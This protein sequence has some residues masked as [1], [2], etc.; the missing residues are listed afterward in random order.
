M[1]YYLWKTTMQPS[2][3]QQEIVD[4]TTGY[5]CVLSPAGSGKTKCI[6]E[7]I[8]QLIENG[9]ESKKILLI[10]FTKKATLEMEERLYNLIGK[11]DVVIGTMHS[12]F[13][14][15]LLYELKKL[16]PKK[17]KYHEILM[18]YKQKKILIEVKEEV[19]FNE[20]IETLL[21]QISQYKNKMINN[22]IIESIEK[23]YEKHKIT[24]DK[25]GNTI[26]LFDFDDMLLKTYELFRDNEYIRNFWGAKWDYIKIDEYQDTNWIQNEIIKYLN[27]SNLM[28][29]GDISQSLYI[30]RGARPEYTQQF[31]E[32][33]P[34]GI[35]HTLNITYRCK[36]EII[37]AANLLINPICGQT[38]KSFHKDKGHVEYLG[39]YTLRSEAK[40]VTEKIKLEIDI[41]SQ[42]EIKILYR[43]NAQSLELEFA[44]NESNIEYYVNNGVSFLDRAICKDLTSY[45][46]VIRDDTQIKH[47]ERIINK[48]NRYL[49]NSFVNQWKKHIK[50]GFTPLES[51]L[52]H[53]SHSYMRT[54]AN[55]LY[56]LITELQQYKSYNIEDLLDIVIDK[57]QY[58]TYVKNNISKNNS[59]AENSESM[60]EAFIKFAST[61]DD[62]NYFSN[63]VNRLT[64][65]QN[66]NAKIQLMTVHGSKGLE[67]DIVFVV[68]VSE[69]VMPHIRGEYGEEMAIAYVAFTRAKSKLY[70]SS[71]IFGNKSLPPSSFLDISN[72]RRTEIMETID[73]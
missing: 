19:N 69:G 14:K 34:D 22:P 60:I 27:P 51:L 9:I 42:I 3:Q 29:V 52:E 1:D 30:F 4:I 62:L 55:D 45:L 46:E 39:H 47:W 36:Q 70:V 21:N 8:A 63:T 40:I 61:F 6:V 2:K 41:N 16:E 59:N 13:F 44:L 32:Y 66:K 17:Y 28:V 65:K 7:N 67:A 64:R 10:T 26:Y 43:T 20:S 38:A 73:F 57:I 23:V 25:K 54:N 56:F 31:L 72:I 33:Y 15:I 49:G 37:K 35:Y 68:G 11:N 58:L 50:N 12:I 18:G 5:H 48:P 71:A 24:K 53:Y